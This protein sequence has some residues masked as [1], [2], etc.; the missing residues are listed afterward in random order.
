MTKPTRRE[1]DDGLDWKDFVK[2]DDPTNPTPE[3]TCRELL[4]L[5]KRGGA[6]TPEKI[7]RLKM[8]KPTCRELLDERIYPHFEGWPP[9][10]AVL[11]LASRVE[12]V[13][14]LHANRMGWCIECSQTAG[15]V[16][17]WPCPTVRG[18]NGEK[19]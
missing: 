2:V 1:R 15:E 16:I 14:A 12:K 6:M 19:P 4:D 8:S 18:L 7:E 9:E 17:P 11:Q 3:S 13:L 5:L 10:T